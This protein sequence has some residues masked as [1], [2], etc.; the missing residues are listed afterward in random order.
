MSGTGIWSWGALFALGAFH[1]I[2]PGMG[3]LFAVSLGLQAQSSRAVWSALGPLALG[4]ALAVAA[5]LAVGAILGI[6]LPLALVRWV[7]A[8]ALLVFGVMHLR[9][10]SHPR[11]GWAACASGRGS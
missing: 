1:G 5:A 6:V 10:H 3:W 2:N 8:A 11:W 9:S 4:H 7:A